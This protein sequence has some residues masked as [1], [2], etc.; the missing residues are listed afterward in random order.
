MSFKTTKFIN[1]HNKTE[2]PVSIE[3]WVD[4]TNEFKCINIYPGEKLIINSSVGEWQL[5]NLINL[6]NCKTTWY[7]G[8]FRSDPCASGNYSW[9]EYD[10]EFEC[11]YSKIPG[12]ISG[13]I[14]F[15][16]K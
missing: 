4:G 12:N 11:E 9:M 14:T 8:K 13:L 15:I 2:I 1:F 3:S 7:I 16:K 6:T 10:D 5:T